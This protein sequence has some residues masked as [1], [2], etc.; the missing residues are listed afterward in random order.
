MWRQEYELFESST[1]EQ[2][3]IMQYPASPAR[4]SGLRI[5]YDLDDN[6]VCAM[7]ALT[8]FYESD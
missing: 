8:L 2:T 5:S 4:T 1:L 6:L 3:S 7:F